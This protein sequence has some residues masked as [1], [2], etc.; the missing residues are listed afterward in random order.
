MLTFIATFSL[1][2]LSEMGDKTQF[3]AMIC[4]AKYGWK[5]VM[6]AIVIAVTS[7]HLL[8]V[9][10]DNGLLDIFHILCFPVAD[11]FSSEYLLFMKSFISLRKIPF[12]ES[13]INIT[14][15]FFLAEMGDK[16][17][18]STIALASQYTSLLSVWLGSTLVLIAADSLGI[19]L[20]PF[21]EKHIRDN[22]I[23]YISAFLFIFC[24]LYTLYETL[25]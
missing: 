25:F 3:I 13:F 1:I 22:H 23:A 10:L 12:K 7:N 24:G 6:T 2:F 18:I 14:L 17:Q 5:K 9:F 21:L 19:A 15:S 4:S 11:L 8:A 16:S 20:G